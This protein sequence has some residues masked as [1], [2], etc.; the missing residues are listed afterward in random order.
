L[1]ERSHIERFWVDSRQLDRGTVFQFVPLGSVGSFRTP[2]GMI[3]TIPSGEIDLLQLAVFG[4]GG[5]GRERACVGDHRQR[6][7]EFWEKATDHPM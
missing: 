7:N 6:D 2:F 4:N 3:P 5:P 1:E